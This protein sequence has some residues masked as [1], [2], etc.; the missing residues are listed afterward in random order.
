MDPG[1]GVLGQDSC[2]GKGG[3]V[4]GENAAAEAVKQVAAW[5]ALQNW[6]MHGWTGSPILGGDGNKEALIPCT[7]SLRRARCL[8]ICCP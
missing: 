7:R 6:R 1:A 3:I 8:R 4:T 2:I 5:L